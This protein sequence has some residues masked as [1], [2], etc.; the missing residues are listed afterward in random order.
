ME[1]DSDLHHSLVEGL[2]PAMSGAP[3]VFKNIV[4]GKVA[5][6][7]DEV[8]AVLEFRGHGRNCCIERRLKA[9]AGSPAKLPVL[10]SSRAR[11]PRHTL[12]PQSR[13]TLYKC[14]SGLGGWG[15]QF[16]VGG[17]GITGSGLPG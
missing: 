11:A 3:H 12:M 4:G 15:I 6:L 2:G 9:A 13:A 16:S 17:F 10:R 7:I 1:P 8:D 5:A 14:W